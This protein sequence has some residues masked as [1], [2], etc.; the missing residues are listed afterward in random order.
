MTRSGLNYLI[1]V[2]NFVVPFEQFVCWQ[3]NFK[4]MLCCPPGLYNSNVHIWSK[5]VEQTIEMLLKRNSAT[6]K[7][8]RQVKVECLVFFNSFVLKHFLFKLSILNQSLHVFL[9]KTLDFIGVNFEGI[10]CKSYKKVRNKLRCCLL[11]QSK[12]S[13]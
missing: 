2:V 11:L 5:N 12:R 7:L 6:S 10:F 4:L 13:G 9:C 8:M 3:F 1:F